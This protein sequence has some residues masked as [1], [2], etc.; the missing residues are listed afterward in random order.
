MRNCVKRKKTGVNFRMRKVKFGQTSYFIS[1]SSSKI[2]VSH[3]FLFRSTKI[4]RNFTE[5]LQT[6]R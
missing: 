1:I 5:K 6:K 2:S 4:I 3:P